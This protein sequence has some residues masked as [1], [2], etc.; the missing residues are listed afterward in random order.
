MGPGEKTFH[1]LLN[2]LLN[3]EALGKVAGL[4][5]RE[6]NDIRT[7]PLDCEPKELDHYPSPYLTGTI[8]VDKNDKGAFFQTTRGCPFR[9]GY[10]AWDRKFSFAEFS[11]D[12]VK[13]EINYFKEANAEALFCVDATFNLN[14]D[15]AIQILNAA[16]D[17]GLEAALWFEAYPRLLTEPFMDALARLPV[18]YIGLGIQT[19]HPEAMKNIDREWDPKKTG[20]LLD[21]LA[22]YENCYQGYETIL[23]LPGDNLETFKETLSWVYRRKP[24]WMFAFPLQVLPDSPLGQRKREFAIEDAGSTEFYE[25]ISN[26]SFPAEEIQVGKAMR[27]WNR[28]MM[29]IL[30]RLTRAT[31]LPAGD[32]LEHWSWYAHNAG[33]HDRLPEYA[34]HEV[35]WDYIEQI[36]QAFKNFCSGMLPS[37][38][39]PDI[40]YPLSELL[41][42][43]HARRRVTSESANFFKTV[44]IHGIVTDTR[45]NRIFDQSAMALMDM[46]EDAFELTFAFDMQ[47]LW[48]LTQAQEIAD[49]PHE[50]HTYLFFMDEEGL[51]VTVKVE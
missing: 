9:C 46:P 6:G 44:D 51:A 18:S 24:S 37:T 43:N 38:G 2:A 34:F 28:G 25:I 7:S 10:C 15:R 12:R 1:A 20:V 5:Y 8:E 40:S 19:T 21:R 35:D 41:R 33:L 26:Y 36:A 11:L 39:H 29:Q 22:R 48:P 13:A 17:V 47:K 42:Y 31:G 3:G 32:L 30:F 50:E 4:A 49:V 16:A 27:L 14:N 45:F 23:G